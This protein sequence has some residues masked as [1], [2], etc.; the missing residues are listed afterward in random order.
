M[1]GELTPNIQYGLAFFYFLAMLLNIGFAMSYS[2]RERKPA[3]GLIWTGVALLFLLHALI[4]LFSAL[5]GGP[6]LV[7]PDWI[8]NLVNAL[9]GPVS[10]FA[11]AVVGFIVF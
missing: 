5:S 4:Y 10:Y 2:S 7:L 6:G 3:H 8:K 11:V 1:H 9:M